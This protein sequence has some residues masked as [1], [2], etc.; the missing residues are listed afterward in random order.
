MAGTGSARTAPG[1]PLGAASGQTPARGIRIRVPSIHFV[2]S[3]TSPVNNRPPATR[4]ALPQAQPALRRSSTLPC[5]SNGHRTAGRGFDTQIRCSALA[6]TAC[7]TPELNAPLS[8]QRASNG[9]PGGSI[10]RRRP[11]PARGASA[12]R[13]HPYISCCQ[14][15]AARKQPH[16]ATR[17]PL[18]QAQPALR[19]SSTLP[20]RT[21]GHGTARRWV[22]W[23]GVCRRDAAVEPPGMDSRRPADR[24]HRGA[25]D[26]TSARAL[27]R[28]TT[29][30]V[31]CGASR[32]PLRRDGYPEAFATKLVAHAGSWVIRRAPLMNQGKA[33]FGRHSLPYDGTQ[34]PPV[35]ATDIER[36]AGGSI[37]RSAFA[38]AACPTLPCRSNGH[39]TAGR[40]FD[41][42]ASAAGMRQSSLQ[43]GFTASRGSNAPGCCRPH[44]CPRPQALDDARRSVRCACSA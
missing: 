43:D 36:R 18:R 28:L 29:R 42:R 25:A 32:L 6:G 40:G 13:C 24:M 41:G 30:G 33:R 1:E 10:L 22:R 37:L 12:F 14:G 17:S 19:W 38:G 9:G 2:L 27:R 15:G 20:C 31:R 11:G 23:A 4:S 39:R 5:R 35:A 8:Q 7:P 44:E 26:D 21:N 16:P 3:R 34:R